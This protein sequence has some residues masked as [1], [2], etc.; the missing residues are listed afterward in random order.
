MLESRFWTWVAVVFIVGLLAGAG[1]VAVY[2]R[3]SSGAQARE[4]KHQLAVQSTQSGGQISTLRSQLA[5]RDATIAALSAQN[6]TLKQQAQ[7]G[8]SGSANSSSDQS[9]AG[10]TETLAWVSRSVSPESVAPT[11]TI[12]LTVKLKGSPDKVSMRVVG[13][14]NGFDET[15]NLKHV[16]TSGSTLT[17]RRTVDAPD[18]KGEYRFYA[19]ATIGSTHST[20]P[21]VS[22][23]TFRVK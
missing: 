3:V 23:Y 6:A 14:T 16:S 18:R 15:Y 13:R 20:M 1:A 7:K 17:W 21:G 5:A 4:L 8:S 12:R 11:G 19:T 9:S 10:E 2:A 22:A